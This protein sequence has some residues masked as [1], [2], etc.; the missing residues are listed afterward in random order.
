MFKDK[1]PVYRLYAKPALRKNCG[2]AKSAES[3]TPL[4]PFIAYRNPLP[5][6]ERPLDRLT[7]PIERRTA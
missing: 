4:R 7:E 2:T 1:V 5:P 3:N 6:N